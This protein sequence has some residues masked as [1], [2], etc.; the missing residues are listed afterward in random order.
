MNPPTYLPTRICS[1]YEYSIY[2]LLSLARKFISAISNRKMLLARN[3]TLISLASEGG[4]VR[5]NGSNAYYI[6]ELYCGGGVWRRMWLCMC[7]TWW[8]IPQQTSYN[9]GRNSNDV[10]SLGGFVWFYP[11]GLMFWEVRICVYIRKT[12]KQ[13]HRKPNIVYYENQHQAENH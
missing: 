5:W 3:Q 8:T 4:S 11:C 7:E 1:T 12:I 6:A 2:K 10:L 13:T 9:I